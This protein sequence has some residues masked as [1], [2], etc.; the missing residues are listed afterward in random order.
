MANPFFDRPI[1]NS[2]YEY[3]LRVQLNKALKRNWQEWDIP[4][5]ADAKWPEGAKALH[6]DW[7]KAGSPSRSSTTSATR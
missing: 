5:E 1:L 6:A 4:R 7:W 3:P 2:P